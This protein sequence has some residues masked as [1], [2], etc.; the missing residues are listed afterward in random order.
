MKF[1]LHKGFVEYEVNYRVAVDDPFVSTFQGSRG[2]TRLWLN[3]FF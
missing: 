2:G 1:Y 3:T